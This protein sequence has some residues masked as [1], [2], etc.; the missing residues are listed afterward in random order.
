M[1]TAAGVADW[2]AEPKA[3]TPPSPRSDW[4]DFS[5]FS[6]E[7]GQQSQKYGYLGCLKPPLLRGLLSS[8]NRQGNIHVQCTCALCL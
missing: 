2:T 6:T 4:A 1:D 7:S 8:Q 5:S 3:T